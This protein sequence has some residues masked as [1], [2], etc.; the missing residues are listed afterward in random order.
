VRLGS[1]SVADRKGLVKRPGEK[2]PV[3]ARGVNGAEGRKMRVESAVGWKPRMQV[4]RRDSSRIE[5]P[6]GVG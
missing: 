3:E 1:D 4:A 6:N 5:S 2:N